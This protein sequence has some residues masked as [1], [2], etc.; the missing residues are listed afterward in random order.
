[1]A[2]TGAHGIQRVPVRVVV[3]RDLFAEDAVRR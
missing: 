1:M 2:T 3:N